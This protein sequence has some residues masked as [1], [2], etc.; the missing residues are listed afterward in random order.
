MIKGS[1]IWAY[2]SADITCLDCENYADV[3]DVST[4]KGCAVVEQ[5]YG[6]TVDQLVN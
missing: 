6:S 3:T 1:G 5:G 4:S 2:K